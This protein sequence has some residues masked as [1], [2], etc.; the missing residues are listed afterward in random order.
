MTIPNTLRFSLF[1]FPRSRAFGRVLLSALVLGT[2]L[3]GGTLLSAAEPQAFD[4]GSDPMRYLKNDRV[5]LGIDL[6]I[7]GAITWLSDEAN[8]GENMI[9]SV[10]WGRQIQLSYYSGPIPYI[11]PNGEQPNDAWRNLGWNPIQSGDYGGYRSR[12]IAFKPMGKNKM[13]VRTIPMLWP[14]SNLPAEAIFECVYTLTPY[15]FILD[16]TI[17]NSRSDTT[18]YPAMRQEMPAIY[19]NGPW[20]KLV[21]Y[22]GTEPF[23]K[24]PVTVLIDKADGRGWPWINYYAP[25][26]WSALVNDDG[27]GLGVFQQESVRITAGFFGGDGLKGVGGPK[28]AQTGYIAPISTMILDH[29]MKRTYRAVFIVGSVDEIRSRV[30]KLAK[31]SLSEIPDWIFDGD[32]HNWIYEGSAKDDGY[33]IDKSLDISFEGSPRGGINSP[34]TFWIAEQAPVLEIDAALSVEGAVPGRTDELT[35]YIAPVSPR[36]MV[37]DMKWPLN[38]EQEKEKAEKAKKYPVLPALEVKVPIAVDGTRGVW[39]VDLRGCEGYTGPMKAISVGLPASK[40]SMKLYE[41][42]FRRDD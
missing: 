8:G 16:A 3:F 28:D 25:E 10:D 29:N 42:R 30:Y 6:S 4:Y 9:N 32:R 13:R 41:I 36:D 35:V 26:R 18:Q 34:E 20:Y 12:V 7:G 23:Q 31:K 40:G 24:K 27:M 5:T 33:P 21:T 17:E 11:G 19:T 14:N 1:D 15:G 22:L 39:R 2:F 37:D 38:P